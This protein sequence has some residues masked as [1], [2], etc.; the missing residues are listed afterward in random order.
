MNTETENLADDFG[1][2]ESEL[3]LITHGTIDEYKDI[4][5]QRILTHAKRIT[6]PKLVKQ[7][8][9]AKGAEK[10]HLLEQLKEEAAAKCI[11]PDDEQLIHYKDWAD[12][13]CFFNP[14]M[15]HALHPH[16]RL[17]Q[18]RALKNFKP[19]SDTLLVMFCGGT[20]PYSSNHNY[21]IYLGAAKQGLFDFM[22][23]SLYPVLVHPFDASRLYPYSISNWP[24]SSSSRLTEVYR[25]NHAEYTREILEK[26]RYKKVIYLHNGLKGR[27]HV[28][29]LVK[30]R[31]PEGCE[32]IDLDVLDQVVASNQA[33]SD[34][35]GLVD[36]R[37]HATR[38][39]R[40]ALAKVLDDPAKAREALKLPKAADEKKSDS[41]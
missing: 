31:A 32:V 35:P 24:H 34:C 21:R 16:W 33:Y 23:A 38:V 39:A 30:A 27:H 5:V 11:A 1:Y 41:L 14:S 29:D 18:D 2:Y 22:V 19:G 20:K 25:R 6:P 17:A 8:R 15:I 36:V 10:E 12:P 4:I 37:W 13:H 26:G 9:R 28:V 40:E 3:K 7:F